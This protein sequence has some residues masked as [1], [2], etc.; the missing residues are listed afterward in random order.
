MSFGCDF[1]C[2]NPSCHCFGM[3]LAIHGPWLLGKIEDVLKTRSYRNDEEGKSSLQ[4]KQAEG[5]P[6]ACIPIPN[7][8]N[9]KPVGIRLQHFC[10]TCRI[11]WD[12][13]IPR[14]EG[15]TDAQEARLIEDIKKTK[16]ICKSC[17]KPCLSYEEMTN[18]IL[19]CPGCGKPT[20]S[21][22]WFSQHISEGD[23]D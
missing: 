15:I 5:R 7:S 9:V 2:Q 10:Q 6:F 12:D 11:L 17:L 3:K 14:P 21:K 16:F 18:R 4:K 1:V 19:P 22:E 8:D 23:E 20:Q 13:D